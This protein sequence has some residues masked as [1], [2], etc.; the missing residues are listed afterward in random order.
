MMSIL[1]DFW[2]WVMIGLVVGAV[3]FFVVVMM[4]KSAKESER[5]TRCY[6]VRDNLEKR[7]RSI[8]PGI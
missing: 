5:L 7:M 3:A 6:K 8:F 4:E 1:I 2:N